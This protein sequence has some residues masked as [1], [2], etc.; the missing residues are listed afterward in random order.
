MDRTGSWDQEYRTNL[1]G[2]QSTFA[3]ALRGNRKRGIVHNL[4]PVVVLAIGTVGIVD[5]KLQG[6]WQSR[7]AT[8]GDTMDMEQRRASTQYW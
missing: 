6:M 1:G 3:F 7:V 2:E 5:D 4:R 8:G